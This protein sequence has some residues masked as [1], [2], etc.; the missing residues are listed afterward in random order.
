MKMSI[1]TLCFVLVACCPISK[2]TAAKLNINATKAICQAVIS[3]PAN[4]AQLET[5]ANQGFDLN[6]NC[7]V[8]QRT[9]FI[10]MTE[11]I[12]S[13]YD[14]IVSEQVLQNSFNQNS[15]IETSNVTP[16]YIALSKKD[17]GLLRVLM[18]HQLDLNRTFPNG[19]LPLEYVL[20]ENKSELVSFLIQHGADPKLV[21]I[22]C[23]FDVELTKKIIRLGANPM[24]IDVSCLSEKSK[25]FNEI[26][27]LL[28]NLHEKNLQQNEVEVL[29]R[30][31]DLLEALL[32]KG[33]NINQSFIMSFQNNTNQKNLLIH[34]I[35]TQNKPVFDLLL[36]HDA[37][38][39][40]IS[41][42]GFT[43]IYYAIHTN[44]IK[45]V[46]A[47]TK[48]GANLNSVNPLNEQTPLGLSI[49]LGFEA[50]TWFL[51]EN[52]A[53]P[54]SPKLAQ[55]N[56]PL[57]KAINQNNK[58]LIRLIINYTDKENLNIAQYFDE[59]HLLAS[60]D[61]VNFLLS[62]GLKNSNEFLQ[63]AIK[64]SQSEIVTILLRHNP[65]WQTANADELPII[66]QAF[67]N[68]NSI[69]AVQLIQSGIDINENVKDQEP[70]LIQAIER[71]SYILVYQ[72]LQVGANPNTTNN[73]GTTALQVAIKQQNID[74]IKALIERKV[75]ITCE[76]FIL[77]IESQ[78]V[79]I[80]KLLHQE[81]GNFDCEINGKSLKYHVR[82]MKP[83]MDIELYLDKN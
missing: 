11:T 49:D 29:F 1:K 60:P 15:L 22:G 75:G 55:E 62:L 43:P 30:K 56:L 47:L 8:R 28:P 23:P 82:K 54:Y 73:E 21:N 20:H 24:T 72:L 59:N 10:S 83:A 4:Y 14:P 33:L 66:Y 38:V 51:L 3:T 25:N 12:V 63:N 18:N 37:S 34:A 17:F 42:K 26:L 78:N 36:K 70:L 69:I 64:N 81:V 77:A 19:L 32:K 68:N 5:F 80:L 48:K 41:S 67:Q 71:N 61:K 45:Y 16:L 9:Q 35:E 6:C 53:A 31:P 27:A 57:V 13:F 65:N 58:T 74:I 44:Q 76:D 50:I 7:L 2:T 39:N 52:G 46:E 79:Y 40:A